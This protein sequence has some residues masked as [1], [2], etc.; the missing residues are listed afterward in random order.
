MN[1]SIAT[2]IAV[3]RPLS[4]SLIVKN[5]E[6]FSGY[7]HHAITVSYVKDGIVVLQGNN[8]RFEFPEANSFIS[9][10]ASD[11]SVWVAINGFQDEILITY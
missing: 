10:M 1:K 5:P 8:F 3:K 9:G 6:G 11:K 4:V 2:L 7:A